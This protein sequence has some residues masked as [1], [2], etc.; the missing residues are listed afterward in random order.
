MAQY[1]AQIN[2]TRGE[3]SHLGT[4]ASGINARINGWDVGVEVCGCFSEALQRDEFEVYLTHGSNAKGHPHLAGFIAL[5]D[6]V[7]VWHPAEAS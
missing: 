4:K 5:V 6:G 7:P 1:R 3:A 2:G